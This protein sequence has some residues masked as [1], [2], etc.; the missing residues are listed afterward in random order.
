M[1]GQMVAVKKCLILCR[2]V[3]EF[4]PTF[5]LSAVCFVILQGSFYASYSPSVVFT[6][7]PVTEQVF[8]VLSWRNSLTEI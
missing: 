2:F 8:L 4:S 1:D 3:W 6:F 7:W 5:G